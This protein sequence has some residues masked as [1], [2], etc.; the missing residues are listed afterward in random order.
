MQE[1]NYQDRSPLFPGGSCFPL[2]G[3]KDDGGDDDRL[4]QLNVIL[5]VIGTPDE[6]ELEGVGTKVTIVTTKMNDSTEPMK[7]SH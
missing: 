3:N 1:G 4:D 5:G 7:F 6:A 2:S